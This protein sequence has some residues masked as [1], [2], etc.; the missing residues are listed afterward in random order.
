MDERNTKERT[1]RKI[2]FVPLLTFQF[3]DL[4]LYLVIK[5]SSLMPLVKGQDW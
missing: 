2:H 4:N 3:L 5:D 1:R